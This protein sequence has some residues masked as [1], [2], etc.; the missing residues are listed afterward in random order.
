MASGGW[1]LK[2]TKQS[3]EAPEQ[4]V[5]ELEPGFEHRLA[6]DECRPRRGTSGVHIN[7]RSP[8]GG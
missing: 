3:S 2:T 4:I 6:D 1:R 7:S 5:V 8:G